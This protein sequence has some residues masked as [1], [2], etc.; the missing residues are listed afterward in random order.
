M[1]ARTAPANTPTPPPPPRAP[2]T[3]LLPIP[4]RGQQPREPARANLYVV[5]DEEQPLGLG[6]GDPRIA[7]GIEP[8]R[9][10][11]GHVP[12]ARAL[13]R[14]PRPPVGPVVD[15]EHLDAL[16]PRLRLDG[17]ERALEVARPPT[18]GNDNRRC[19]RHDR[20]AV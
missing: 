17:R 3:A 4:G 5:V 9:P 20:R 10:L 14:R 19:Q 8:E 1:P 13:R 15:H 11:V 16:A 7:R 2:P 18:G 6:R 12:R